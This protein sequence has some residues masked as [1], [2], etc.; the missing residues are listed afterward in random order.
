MSKQ[1]YTDQ[2]IVHY[3]LGSLPE[4]ETANFDELTVTDAGF[5][6][7]VRAAEKELVDAYVQGALTGV[8]LARFESHYLMSP[9][10]RENVEFART[11]QIAA[12]KYSVSELS[13]RFA[14]RPTER[15]RSA[16]F[17]VLNLFTIPRAAVPWSLA[18][19]AVVILIASGWL[20]R[21]KAQRQKQPA[22]AFFVLTPPMRSAE[23]IPSISFPSKTDH[24]AMELE[25]ESDDY[26]AYD[27]VLLDQSTNR[28][29]WRSSKL[30]AETV[31][32][33]KA[34]RI[35]FPAI[36]LT[37]KTYLLRVSGVPA[38]GGPEIISDYSFVVK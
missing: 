34:L 29:L 6:E 23:Q 30:M 12:L 8:S 20:L 22:I 25:L 33:R 28:A 35:S 21:E 9:H 19:M 14:E 3:L 1:L 24:V 27:V 7:T 36:L 32:Q 15:P 26:P 31:A 18:T 4:T 10:R 38:T 37:S 11:F 16:R 2:Q 13:E 5:A 17:S